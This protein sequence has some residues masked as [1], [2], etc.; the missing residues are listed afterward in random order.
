MI[1][2]DD[3]GSHRLSE[4]QRLMLHIL[5]ETEPDASSELFP[6]SPAGVAVLQAAASLA[7]STSAETANKALATPHPGRVADDGS[8]GYV[9]EAGEVAI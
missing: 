7:V 4:Q 1:L 9:E 2:I 8:V 3:T 5:M 6:P